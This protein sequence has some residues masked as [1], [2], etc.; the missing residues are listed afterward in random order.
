MFIFV[1]DSCE[2]TIESATA[3]SPTPVAANAAAAT[4]A[5]E[6]PKAA[7]KK[8]PRGP[9]RSDTPDNASSIRVPATKLDQFVNLVGELVTVQ[10][11]LLRL[12]PATKI[13]KW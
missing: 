1:E 11:R 2:L 6:A 8:Y 13:P 3:P 9:P 12:P 4:P 5:P 10:A 7:D